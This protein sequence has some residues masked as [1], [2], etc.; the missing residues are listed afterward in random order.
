MINS[1]YLSQYNLF[2]C[3]DIYN[4]ILAA[5]EMQTLKTLSK[6][7]VYIVHFMDA[8]ALSKAS[9]IYVALDLESKIE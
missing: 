6:V 2:G 5:L 1:R 9:T 8:A 7:F 4:L 3:K